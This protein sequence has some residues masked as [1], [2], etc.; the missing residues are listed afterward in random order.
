MPG[1]AYLDKFAVCK[2]ERGN[3]S[4]DVLWQ[5]LKQDYTS[6]YWRSRRTNIFNSWSVVVN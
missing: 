5:Q 3:F 2:E 6:L 4:I 1:V